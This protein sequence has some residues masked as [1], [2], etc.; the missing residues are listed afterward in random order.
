MVTGHDCPTCGDIAV[1]AVVVTVDGLEVDRAQPLR[2]RTD[3]TVADR[4]MY[5]RG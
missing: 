4:S 2:D 3:R 5:R 1:E